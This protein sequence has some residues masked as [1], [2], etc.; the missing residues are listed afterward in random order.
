[1]QWEFDNPSLKTGLLGPQRPRVLRID[2]I[3]VLKTEDSIWR[4][5]HGHGI[6]IPLAYAPGLIAVRDTRS[7]PTLQG[8]GNPPHDFLLQPF[9]ATSLPEYYASP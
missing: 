8:S 7:F 5:G 6:P 2:V 4:G 1:M 9:H 3:E